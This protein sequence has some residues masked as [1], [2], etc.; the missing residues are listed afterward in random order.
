M[1]NK[2]S[3]KAIMFAVISLIIDVFR[4]EDKG[5]F[6]HTHT[7]THIHTYPHTHTHTNTH[8]HKKKQRY[9]GY[10]YFPFYFDHKIS[11]K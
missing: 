7:N 6:T 10:V 8:T 3:L 2:V 1:F 9:T 5:H 11:K 4:L